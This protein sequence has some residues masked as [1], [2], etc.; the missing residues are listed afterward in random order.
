MTGARSEPGIDRCEPMAEQPDQDHKLTLADDPGQAPTRRT[1]HCD[2][3]TVRR[4]A[5]MLDLEPTPFVDGAPLPP[6]WH[7]ALLGGETRRSDLRAD[8]FPGFGVPMPDLGLPGLLLAGR[9]V[10]Y[11]SPLVIG[12]RIERLSRVQ[13]VIQKHGA[14]GPMAIVTI[15]HELHRAA[16]EPAIVETQT[17]ILR[18]R[19]RAAAKIATPAG[20]VGVSRQK[21]VQPDETLLFQY[22]AL[23]FN[24]HKIHID[25]GWARDVEG[26]PDLVVNGGLASLLLMEFLRTDLSITPVRVTARHSAPLYCGRLVTLTAVRQETCWRARAFDDVGTLALEMEVVSR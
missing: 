15:G 22:S 10:E 16:D 18:G 19:A 4:I 24:S 21:T 17:Y 23:G 5:A 14:S 26:L 11:R 7:F 20:A 6:G 13:S 25:R 12:E 8:G 1:L 9:T 3:L 2:A